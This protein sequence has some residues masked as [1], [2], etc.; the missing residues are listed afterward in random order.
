MRPSR[1]MFVA[2]AFVLMGHTRLHDNIYI[3]HF[4]VSLPS[5]FHVSFVLSFPDF[6]L[7]ARVCSHSR[8]FYSISKF[9]T[10]LF[11]PYL[12]L[13]MI[14][15]VIPWL[16][17]SPKMSRFHPFQLAGIP[18]TVVIWGRMK[19][20]GLAIFVSYIQTDLVFGNFYSIQPPQSSIVE[21][22]IYWAVS[23]YSCKQY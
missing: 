5:V 18:G 4:S 20:A 21:E 22:P 19:I 6:P 13:S 14:L 15:C 8:S 2:L 23:K 16:D 3:N 1:A 9:C 10:S 17:H 11:R 12:S 7:R